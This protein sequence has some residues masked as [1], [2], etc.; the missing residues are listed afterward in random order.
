MKKY[1]T[2]YLIAIFV[3][4]ALFILEFFIFLEL[5]R[6]YGF[7]SERN[8]LL[9]EVK[10]LKINLDTYLNNRNMEQATDN[11]ISADS[12]LSLDKVFN[13][14]GITILKSNKITGL[15]SSFDIL[16]VVDSDTFD[17][18]RYLI[19]ARDFMNHIFIVSLSDSL[20][21]EEGTVLY[22]KLKS[23]ITVTF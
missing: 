14:N 7:I 10:N 18:P 13:D 23:I 1:I 20:S 17:N 3:L 21:A 4:L 2:L 8:R 6:E 5:R 16:V 12:S 9:V 19:L 22:E 11:I 15:H